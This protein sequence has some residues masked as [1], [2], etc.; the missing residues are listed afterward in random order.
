LIFGECK[1]NFHEA[2]VLHKQRY[3]Y[4]NHPSEKTFKNIERYLR[5]NG[6]FPD[7]KYLNRSII[8]NNNNSAIVLGHFHVNPYSIRA[9]AAETNIS[10]ESIHR[11]IKNYKYPF[12]L[13]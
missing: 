3:P 13:T 2:T 6:K 9:V 7:G 1:R 8:A 10:V 11:I 5:K 12:K 4:R